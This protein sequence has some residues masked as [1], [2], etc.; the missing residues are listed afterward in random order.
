MVDEFKIILNNYP[1]VKSFVDKQLE[2]IS[3]TN[4][5]DNCF[6]I[7]NTLIRKYPRTSVKS[8]SYEHN[9]A[10]VI[11]CIEY[12]IDESEQEIYYNDLLEIHNNNIQYEKENPID[13]KIKV[14][15]TKSTKTTTKPK[16]D[17]PPKEKKE[18]AAERKLKAHAEK[19]SKLGGI[20][21]K[22]SIAS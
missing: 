8:C 17:K 10:E 3:V 4:F 19:L 11:Y 20:S 9:L 16:E 13:R 6:T 7:A 18:S 1:D 5:I 12:Y 2:S 21:F 22:P 15:K 14:V